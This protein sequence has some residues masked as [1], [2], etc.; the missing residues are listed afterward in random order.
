MSYNGTTFSDIVPAHLDFLTIFSPE[1]GKTN[2]TEK[3]QIVFY[4]SKPLKRRKKGTD[5]D[6]KEEHHH[7]EENNE[8]MRQVGLAQGMVHFA[9]TFGRGDNVESIDTEKHRIVVKQLEKD[10]WILASIC[11]TRILKQ[12]SV[13]ANEN[14]NTTKRPAFDYSAREVS[15]PVL[16]IEQLLRAN[17]SFL[18]HHSQSLSDLWVRLRRP[19]FCGILEKYW[20]KFARDWNVMLHGCP[21]VDAF[22]AI[23]LAAAGE[24]GV[25]VGE[26]EWGSGEREVLEGLIRSTEGLLDILVLR[27]D[28]QETGP[29]SAELQ[30]DDSKQNCSLGCSPALAQGV[31]FNGV[32]NITRRSACAVTDWMQHVATF[33]TKAYGIFDNPASTRPKLQRNVSSRVTSGFKGGGL[34]HDDSGGHK[35]GTASSTKDTESEHPR[36]PIPPSIMSVIETSL[37]AATKSAEASDT[38]EDRPEAPPY[39]WK[40]LS[41]G[42]WNNLLTFGYGTSWGRTSDANTAVDPQNH[43]NTEQT[44]E[45][46][47]QN[48]VAGPRIAK[49]QLNKGRFLIGLTGELESDRLG[50]ADLDQQLRSEDSWDGR[51]SVRTIQVELSQTT[52]LTTPSSS[53]VGSESGGQ[54]PSRNPVDRSVA[55]HTTR[56]RLVLYDD[57]PFLYALIFDPGTHSLAIPSFYRSLHE[58]LSPIRKTLE[59]CTSAERVSQRLSSSLPTRGLQ[60]DVYDLVYDPTNITVRSSIPDI[61]IPHDP[62]TDQPNTIRTWTRSEALNVHS[63]I[64]STLAEA[65]TNQTV[66]ELCIKTQRDWWVDWMRFRS[67]HSNEMAPD[68]LALPSSSTPIKEHKEAIMVRKAS[69]E[70][71]TKTK[72]HR[73]SRSL[74]RLSI[75]SGVQAMGLGGLVGQEQQNE[76]AFGEEPDSAS[77]WEAGRFAEGTGID[78]RKYIESLFN[79]NR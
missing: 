74:G 11:L 62:D 78:P 68:F 56:M 69:E 77:S 18:L 20:S 21:A 35:P 37:D 45:T 15:P 49:Q 76:N 52:G 27:N 41:S 58:S 40:R 5:K 46:F 71:A 28:T 12:S 25:G 9:R 47:D 73:K 75:S 70:G 2:G 6:N 38:K 23:K 10:W 53:R 32:G 44:L 1:L 61:P 22:S 50:I 33:K 3:D 48:K 57:A 43:I 79:L 63:Q 7:K 60:A 54:S 66:R 17:R 16:L 42:N 34:D 51:L 30:A 26:E 4:W 31:I 36:A 64:L 8:R 19:K 14:S 65:R 67:K 55:R 39:S 29:A 24:L 59:Q 13:N 72:S